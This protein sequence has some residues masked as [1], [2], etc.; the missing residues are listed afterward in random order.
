MAGK[1]KKYIIPYPEPSDTV[2]ELPSTLKKFAERIESLVD[3]L[4]HGRK[5]EDASAPSNPVEHRLSS[6]VW[7]VKSGH[8][9]SIVSDGALIDSG[10]T[11]PEG[12]RPKR[13][14]MLSAVRVSGGTVEDVI[15][16]SV[17][18]N[19]AVQSNNGFRGTVT[20]IADGD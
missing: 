11:L 13:T 12:W 17:N 18:R 1:T 7:A 5:P 19:G 4:A 3:N 20:F 6:S 15:W 14:T 10:T 8:V 16:V 2:H 9:V